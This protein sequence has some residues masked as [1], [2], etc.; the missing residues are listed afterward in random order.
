MLAA[1]RLLLIGVPYYIQSNYTSTTELKNYSKNINFFQ[2]NLSLG[3]PEMILD[4]QMMNTVV[5]HFQRYN[6]EVS[7]L[8]S[9]SSRILW[10]F[11][12]SHPT[13]EFPLAKLLQQSCT[14]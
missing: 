8:H 11:I 4:S 12:S 1:I 3:W 10:S 9:S 14:K 13:L 2:L 5:S 6:Q 7:E